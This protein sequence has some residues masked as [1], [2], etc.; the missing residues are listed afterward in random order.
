MKEFI[1]FIDFENI[2]FN[3]IS[4]LE[5]FIKIKPEFEFQ[6]LPVE[7]KD[8]PIEVEILKRTDIND[9]MVDDFSYHDY[10]QYVG[11][12]VFVLAEENLLKCDKKMKIYYFVPDMSNKRNEV[13]DVVSILQF[14]KFT[15]K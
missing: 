7:L 4:K 6:E 5:K 9:Y 11:K 12:F 13:L 14:L 15:R 2:I 10:I 8:F 1:S 3:Y